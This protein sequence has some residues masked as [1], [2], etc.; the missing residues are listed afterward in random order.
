MGR[1]DTVKGLI[2]DE[3]TK[4]ERIQLHVRDIQGAIERSMKFQKRAK[5]QLKEIVKLAE[6]FER[7][8]EQDENTMNE[9]SINLN[10]YN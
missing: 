1:R 3:M 8:L 10:N 6:D 4:G 5:R 7:E 2:D 9:Y